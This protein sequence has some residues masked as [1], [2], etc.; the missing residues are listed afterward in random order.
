MSAF[1]LELQSAG[2]WQQVY[3]ESREGIPISEKH[4]IPIPAFEIGLLFEHHILAVRCISTTAKAHWRFAGN[5]SQR[6]QIGTGG[7]TS[8]LP[9]VTAARR[10]LRLN[11]AELIRFPRL[12]TNYELLFEVPHWIKDMRLTVWEYSGIESDTTEETLIRIEDRM[13]SFGGW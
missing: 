13:N 4:H 8:P 3:N 12:T 7:S 10:G 1:I 2:V 6:F 9:V 5:L 11:R